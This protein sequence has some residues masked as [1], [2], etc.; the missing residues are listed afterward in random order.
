[1]ATVWV[2]IAILTVRITLSVCPFN[3]MAHTANTSF[4]LICSPFFFDMNISSCPHIICYAATSSYAHLLQAPTTFPFTTFSD[5]CIRY[6]TTFSDGC[7]RYRRCTWVSPDMVDNP[8]T[9]SSFEI[10][11]QRDS[12]N[13]LMLIPNQTLITIGIYEIG[14]FSPDPP[15]NWLL[16]LSTTR[17]HIT[18]MPP[19]CV[20]DCSLRLLE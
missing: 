10:P 7:I 3:C 12:F 20:R 14:S 1:M 5:G 6:F 4:C 18:P 15:R 11:L 16:V 8:P 9:H 17:H 2:R 13:L 19:S